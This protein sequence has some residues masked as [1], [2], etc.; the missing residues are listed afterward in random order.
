MAKL[1]AEKEVLRQ[2]DEAGKARRKAEEEDAKRKAE[3]QASRLARQRSRRP[4]PPPDYD[5]TWADG[6]DDWFQ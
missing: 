4:S 2:K 6:R 5:A 1:Q 3:V